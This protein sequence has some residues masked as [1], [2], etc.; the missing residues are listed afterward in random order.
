MLIWYLVELRKRHIERDAVLTYDRRKNYKLIKRIAIKYNICS[1]DQVQLWSLSE[2]MSFFLIYLHL[3]LHCHLG[4]IGGVYGMK[5]T[6]W[7]IPHN[8]YFELM[9]EIWRIG[10]KYKQKQQYNSAGWIDKSHS[11]FLHG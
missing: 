9:K 2:P 1:N 6:V 8:E 11:R 7:L 3:T 10:W 5:H 4:S